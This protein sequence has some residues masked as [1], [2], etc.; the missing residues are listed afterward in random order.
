MWRCKKCGGTSFTEL[1]KGGYR[2]FDEYDKNGDPLED[3]LVD[4][5]PELY[6]ECDECGNFGLKL[7]N[8]AEWKEEE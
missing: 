7:Q 1:Y 4:D 8:I 5:D 3:S 2:K 6:T